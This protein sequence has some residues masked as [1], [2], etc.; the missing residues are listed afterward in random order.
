MD[1]PDLVPL[2]EEYKDIPVVSISNSQRFPL[3]DIN[4]RRTVY[5]G[6]PKELYKLYNGEGQYLSFIG[7]FSPEKRADRAIELAKQ[8][9]IPLKIAAKIEKL[10]QEYFDNNIKHLLNHSLIDYMGE[11]GEKEKNEFLGNALALVFLIDW[12]EPFGLV[13]I[14]AM[15]CGTPVIAWDNGSVPEIIED[16]VNGF[17]VS[18]MEEAAE[19]VKKIHTI[20]RKIVRKIFEEKFSSERMASDYINVYEEMVDVKNLTRL[21]RLYYE[22]I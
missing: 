10:D 6:L 17:I 5:H 4:W 14:E 16:G 21:N 11:I 13:M 15:A 18:S 19:A 2:Y 3:P 22:G 7:R 1:L 8:T 12:P 9:G 20:D